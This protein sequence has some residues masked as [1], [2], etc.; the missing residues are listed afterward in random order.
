MS[1]NEAVPSQNLQQSFPQDTASS[2]SGQIAPKEE[3]QEDMKQM[4]IQI[5]DITYAVNL[6]ENDTAQAFMQLLPL[7]IDMQELN[8]NEK[9]AYLSQSLPANAQ[10]VSAIHAG[11]LMLFGDDCIVLF[12]EDFST[13]YRYTK[14]GYIQNPESLAEVVGTGTANVTFRSSAHS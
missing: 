2:E 6:Y 8:G 12:Y 1:S 11:D 7:Q 5:G 4:E 14:I 3:R 13:S 9:Y 10:S